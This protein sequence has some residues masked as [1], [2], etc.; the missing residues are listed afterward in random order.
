[1]TS[2]AR[3]KKVLEFYN[4]AGKLDDAARDDLIVVL[5]EELCYNNISLKPRDF[6]SIVNEIYSI[7]PSESNTKVIV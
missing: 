3:G 1:M 5:V 2:T 7:F 4:K 6:P